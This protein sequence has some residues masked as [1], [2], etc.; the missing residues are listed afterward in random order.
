VLKKIKK[1]VKHLLFVLASLFPLEWLRRMANRQLIVIN[2]HSIQDADV[3]PVINTNKYRSVKEF[4]KDIIFL[5]SF[6]TGI[7]YQDVISYI[8]KGAGIPQH[9]FYLTFDDGLNIVYKAFYPLL[10]KY[11]VNAAFFL[12]PDFVDNHDLHF[13]RKKNLLKQT[14][15]T[16]VIAQTKELWTKLFEDED[17]YGEDFFKS[18]EEV[19]FSKSYILD[20][21]MDLFKL[22]LKKYLQE[23]QIYLNS[24][25]IRE[26]IDE[27]FAFGGHSINHPKYQ[28][29]SVEE[30]AE[31][32]IESIRWVKEHF[33]LDYRLFAFPLRDQDISK[34][35]FNKIAGECEVT[36]GVNGISDD[37][38]PF[39]IHR[40]DVESTD[41]KIEWVLK[42]EYLKFLFK[43]MLGKNRLQRK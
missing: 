16:G 21:L 11:K 19:N 17:I 15:Q 31:Q 24:D 12:N 39:H 33:A 29:L 32:T 23:H 34:S 7:T 26:M 28:E 40:I 43:R 14:I 22:D 20:S 5:S 42:F 27:G 18:L 2:Y 30:Q 1:Q 41:V 35:L 36:F 38:I 10:K 3:D 13:Q 9:S 4:E 37:Q 25:A 6:Y 8:K